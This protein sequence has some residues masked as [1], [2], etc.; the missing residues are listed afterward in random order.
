MMTVATAASA[1]PADTFVRTHCLKVHIRETDYRPDIDGLRAIAV[2]AV[3][4]FHA[5]PSWLPG[6]F[7]G[8]DIFF[9]ISGYLISK[10]ILAELE[11]ATFSTRAFYFRRIKRIFPALILILFVCTVV[12]WVILTPG[13]YE[14]LGRPIAGGAGFVANFV[15]WKEAG[16]FDMAADTK[17]LLHLW[18]LGIEEQ[19]YIVWP[20][21]LAVLWRH[22]PQ[23]LGRA[24]LGFLSVSLLYSV[25]LV[26]RDVTADFYSPL[27][28]FWE[29]GLGAALAYGVL[30]N[31][32]NMGVPHRRLL[33]WF[34]LGLILAAVVTI[35]KSGRFPGAWALLPTVGAA[36]LIY[37][38]GGGQVTWLNRT[39]LASRPLVW[40]GLISY[41]LYLW[42][43]PLLSFARIIESETPAVDVRVALIGTSIVLA[44]FTYRFAE[45][46]VR[47]IS[48]RHARKLVSLLGLA[49]LL[50]F[51]AGV[52][53]RKSD[54]FKF[55][56]LTK[57]NG[58]VS[59]LT[60]GKDRD[61]LR[62]E[63]GLP[64]AQKHLFQFCLSA[65]SDAPRFAVLGDS[66]GEALFY[67][68]ARESGS[69]THG[70]LIG[71]VR[72]PRRDASPDDPREIKSRLAFQTI[73]DNPSIRVVVF[74][75]AL[76]STF[77]LNDDTGFIEGDTEL[78]TAGWITAYGEAIRRI[79]Q[80]GKR[81]VFVID[82]PTFPDP[83]SCISG[84]MTSSS[85]LNQ[86]L[87]RKQNPRCAIR[88]T[89]HLAG[90]GAYRQLATNLAKDNPHL[91]IYDPT[92]LL[93][94][95]SRNECSITRDGKFL[96]GYSDH[97]S[98]YAN[99]LIARE[100]LP[101]IENLAH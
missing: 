34:G 98:D 76:R 64:E 85:F 32:L 97:I 31:K 45:L 37:S 36:C 28:R 52:V 17:P 94:D 10:H 80:A 60:I 47:A 61:A 71:S 5:F 88:Y 2:L 33:S 59:T 13:E 65:S 74:V 63:C 66:K 56:A 72:P 3:I 92:P 12:G 68:L 100:L 27:T 93:C 46:P 21:I 77:T 18:S 39:A 35:E 4:G 69:G 57:L 101:L 50:I 26:H 86:F 70:V 79:E 19:F 99:S 51:V 40:I 16:Y 25:W 20:F 53:V 38:G 67:G 55:R 9:V 23:L 8:V 81:A 48:A 24:I 1:I 95:I 6:G 89:D 58:D 62:N 42:H 91:T 83:R 29:L 87:H 73:L 43:W 90:T 11:A 78:T 7:I 96:Y 49:M 44:W 54:G 30:H 15:F 14:L 84:G 22:A 41:P 82:N 75:I